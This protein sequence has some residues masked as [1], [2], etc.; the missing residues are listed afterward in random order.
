MVRLKIN[1]YG[2]DTSPGLCRGLE[3]KKHTHVGLCGRALL[4]VLHCGTLPDL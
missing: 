2:T 4:S 1:G 3:G